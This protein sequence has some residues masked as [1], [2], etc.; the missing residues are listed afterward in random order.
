MP[1]DD[2]A[3]GLRIRPTFVFAGAILVGDWRLGIWDWDAGIG[4][5]RWGRDVSGRSLSSYGDVEEARLVEV[6]GSAGKGTEV[7]R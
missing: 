2:M 4:R 6:I 1:V 7:E 3:G 5:E